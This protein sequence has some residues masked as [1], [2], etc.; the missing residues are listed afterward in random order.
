MYLYIYLVATVHY[1][2]QLRAF[3]VS[4]FDSRQNNNN[5]RRLRLQRRF[6]GKSCNR[7]PIR[8]VLFL[9]KL[10]HSLHD[11]VS[12]ISGCARESNSFQY[13]NDCP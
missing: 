6:I 13:R 12:R 9:H 3:H 11:F 4:S 10:R 1:K 5:F 7:R 2:L 8:H